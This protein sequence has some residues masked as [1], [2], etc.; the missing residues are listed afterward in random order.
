MTPPLIDLHPDHW[1]IVRDILQTHVPQYPVW[2][3][4]S[5]ATW[6]A[7]EFSDLDLAIITETPLPLDVAASLREAFSDSDLPWKVDVVDWASTSA[8]FREIIARDK[9]EVQEGGAV[10]PIVRL[11]D[12]IESNL[13]KMLDA[14]KNKGVLRPYLGNSNV[15]WGAFDLNDLSLMKFEENENERYGI[16]NGDLIVCEGGEPGR[17]AIWRG[18]VTD[19]KI[20]KALHRIRPREGLDNYY[21]FYWFMLAGRFGWL[22]P[23]FT[24]TTIKHL[25]GK[26]LSELK[27]PLP[28]IKE[29]RAIASVLLTLDDKIDLNRRMNATLEAMARALFKDWFVDF[30]PTRAKLEGRAPYLAPELWALFPDQ[31][32]EEGIPKGWESTTVGELLDLNYG[33]ALTAS[34]RKIGEIPV[35][36]SG[37]QTGTHSEPLVDGPAVIV[38]RKGSVGTLYWVDTPVFPI[39]TVFFIKIKRCS[40]LFSYHLLDDKPLS[41]MNTDA[42]VPG[43]NRNNVYRL[44]AIWPGLKLAEQFDELVGSL[45]NKRSA[46]L[47]ESRTLAQ[48]RDLLLPKLISGEIRLNPAQA[49][50]LV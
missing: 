28:N 46:N 4:G 21:L 17:C 41:E 38:G 48:T 50:P 14:Q 16:R 20:Q 27:I 34:S 22:E 18:E 45:W 32:D 33:K 31:L 29:Q 25:T 10:R 3:F 49:G 39:D 43:L 13:G 12:Y 23:F 19:M 36:G 35:F 47:D 30:G 8:T 5:R 15:R 1:A 44:P 37:G 26:A 24:G 6:K 9:V 7:K 2:A 11:G 42:A 40:L